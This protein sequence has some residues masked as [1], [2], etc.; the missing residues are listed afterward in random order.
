MHAKR[1]NWLSMKI[2]ITSFLWN[3]AHS[4]S[5]EAYY[6]LTV[7]VEMGGGARGGDVSVLAS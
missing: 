2:M 6:P 7:T 3:I 4:I 1:A 5:F